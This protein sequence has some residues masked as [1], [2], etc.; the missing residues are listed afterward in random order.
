MPVAR[1]QRP[2]PPAAPPLLL[3]YRGRDL[4]SAGEA[5]QMLQSVM[6]NDMVGRERWDGM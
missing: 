3:R 5:E 6:R 1:C 4:P 2:D